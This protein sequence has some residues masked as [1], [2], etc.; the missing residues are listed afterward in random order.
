MHKTRTIEVTVMFRP[1]WKDEKE[2]WRIRKK[3][4]NNGT[5]STKE[6]IVL[7]CSPA[8]YKICSLSYHIE[9]LNGKHETTKGRKKSPHIHRVVRMIERNNEE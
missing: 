4:E 1:S 2:S 3:G 7:P 6:I 8:L 5:W 9:M